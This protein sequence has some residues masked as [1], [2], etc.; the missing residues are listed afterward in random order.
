MARPS[1]GGLLGGLGRRMLGLGSADAV[2]PRS[3]SALEA[4]STRRRLSVWQPIQQHINAAMYAAG[5]NATA[6]ARWLVRNNGYAKAALRSWSAA[7]VGPGIKPSSLLADPVLRNAVNQAW[8][9]WTDEADAEGLTDFYG[10]AR[11]VAREAFIAGEVFIRLRPRLPQDRLSVP[12]QLQM[13]P[14]EQL[15]LSKIEEAPN[16]NPIRMG[17]EFD[18]N[19][20]EKRVAYWFYRVNPSDTTLTFLEAMQA[21]QLTRVPA[22]EVIH[23]F[24]PVEAGQIRGLTGYQAAMVK[25]F[26]MD[27]YDDAE[28]ERKKQIARYAAFVTTPAPSPDEIAAGLLRGDDGNPLEP[29][30]QDDAIHYGP[31]SV[32]TLYPGEDVKFSEPGEVGGSYEP[33]QYRTLLQITAAL[34]VPYGELSGDLSKAT[35][36]SSR[37]GLLAFRQEVEAFQHG[38]LV[39]LFLRHVWTR[40]MDAAVLAGRLPITAAAYNADPTKWRRMKAITPRMPWVDPLKDRQANALALRIGAVAPQDVIEAEGY[41]AEETLDRWQEWIAMLAARELPGFDYGWSARAAGGA[42]AAATDGGA[43]QQN[44]GAAA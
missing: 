3:P 13:L 8:L 44:A 36:A 30:P 19:L 35:Y 29:R 22:S 38:V 2:D 33:F 28:L 9:D 24:D 26:Q 31:G 12:L 39:F 7:T 20:R 27:L 5:P 32:V 17:V 16:G 1:L 11:R 42:P 40:W 21:G 15:P 41:D 23:V 18:R 14:S 10:L 37:A 6:R 25:L 34:G 43:E 4:G